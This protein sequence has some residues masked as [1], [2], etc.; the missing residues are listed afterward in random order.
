MH[1]ADLRKARKHNLLRSVTSIDKAQFPNPALD[2]YKRDQMLKAA[3][4]NPRQPHEDYERYAQRLYELSTQH[5]DEAAEFGTDLHKAVENLPF[6]PDGY[7]KPYIEKIMAWQAENVI[8]VL[9]QEQVVVDLEIGVAGRKD[10][11]ILHKTYGVL[12]LDWKT[13]GIK[14]DEK[15]RKKKPGFYPSFVR[16]LAFYESVDA[17]KEGRYPK[18]NHAL[19]IVIDSTEAA[20]P[21]ERLWTPEEMHSAYEDFLIATY[22]YYKSKDYW[23]IGRWDLQTKLLELHK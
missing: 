12:P 19:S 14:N 9:E 6:I 11:K 8:S 4:E 21:Y 20:N 3:F 7:L 18:F 2:I 15:G 10:Q 16:Q 17:K 1:D 13:Q 5:R 22:M 23:P